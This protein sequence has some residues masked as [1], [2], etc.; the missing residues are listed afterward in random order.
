MKKNNFNIIKIDKFNSSYLNKT[1]Q[2][3]SDWSSASYY[4]SFIAVSYTHLRAHE[5]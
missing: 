5:T 1:F 3:E 4:Y 2:V